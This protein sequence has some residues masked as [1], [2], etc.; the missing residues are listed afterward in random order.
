MRKYL[1]VAATATMAVLVYAQL[2]A[3]QLLANYAKTLSEAKSLKVSYTVISTDGASQ[4][5]QLA[6]AKP[7]MARIETPG[8]VIT[9]DGTTLV[10]FD[11]A[12]KT[13]Y[14]DPQN[15][16]VLRG[17]LNEDQFAVWNAFFNGNA[18]SKASAKS[19]G[20]MN[21]KG[22]QLN[23]VEASFDDG[24]KKI[25]YYLSPQD[26]LAR[27]AEI[28]YADTGSNKLIVNTKSIEVGGD[29]KAESFAFNAPAGSHELTEE[30]RLSAEWYD[31]LEKAKEVAAKTKR[32][33]FIDFY[34]EW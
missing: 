15:D 4:A 30:E 13:Y 2:S 9:A 26:S 12:Q 31:D 19:L 33:I 25:V 16:Q 14:R 20:T 10:H 3:G 21:R 28:G 24:K 29:A 17:L 18:F 5:Y 7:N 27:Q 34:A 23:A 1:W 6:L 22:V 32:L 11:K 8:E